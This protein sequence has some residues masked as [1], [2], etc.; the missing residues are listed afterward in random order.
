[1]IT[2][3]EDTMTI[4]PKNPDTKWVALDA[5]DNIISEGKTPEEVVDKAKNVS[6]EFF[7]M[8]VPQEGT[9]YIF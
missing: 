3:E 6:G 1:M 2:A 7:L 4:T 8:F 5:N 9:T